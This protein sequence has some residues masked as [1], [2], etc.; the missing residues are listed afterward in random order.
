MAALG[1]PDVTDVLET[2]CAPRSHVGDSPVIGMAE[3][4]TPVAQSF[5]AIGYVK[6]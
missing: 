2:A 6:D 3:G 1:L 5:I 4:L